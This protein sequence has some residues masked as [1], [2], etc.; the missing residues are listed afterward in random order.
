MS[1]VWRL[2]FSMYSYVD[3]GDYNTAMLYINGDKVDESQHWTYSGSGWVESTSG[4]E[5]TRE[6][7]QGDNIELRTT[8]MNGDYWYINYCAE[9][10][11]KL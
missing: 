9:Y 4:R 5:L 6:F 3:S 10:V 11:P 2:T 8:Q 7:S 1:G